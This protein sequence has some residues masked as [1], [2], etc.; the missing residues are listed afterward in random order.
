MPLGCAMMI[1]LRPFLGLHSR[2]L[3]RYEGEVCTL[4]QLAG[5]F[6]PGLKLLGH[7]AVAFAAGFYHSGTVQNGHAAT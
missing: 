5:F 7:D 4:A 6:F 2:M 3:Q 1:C